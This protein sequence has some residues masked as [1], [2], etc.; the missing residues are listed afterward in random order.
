MEDPLTGFPPQGSP[1]R[2]PPEDPS[3]GTPQ[4]PK[5]N[6][7]SSWGPEIHSYIMI[8]FNAGM[9]FVNRPAQ[10]IAA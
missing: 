1:Q 6:L 2:I 10:R 8:G 5:Q 3:R 9:I 4:A 7:T